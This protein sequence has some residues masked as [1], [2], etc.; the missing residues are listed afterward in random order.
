MKFSFMPKVSS[1]ISK[2]NTKIVFKSNVTL[3]CEYIF[4]Y[5]N[6]FIDLRQTNTIE[7]LLGNLLVSQAIHKCT[8]TEF[9]QVFSYYIFLVL[10]SALL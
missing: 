7:L 6:L 4:F 9:S 5:L 3:S 2:G 8:L 1:A 10:L